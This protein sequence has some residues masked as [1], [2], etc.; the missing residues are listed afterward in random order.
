[1]T[2]LDQRIDPSPG[3]VLLHQGAT[4]AQHRGTSHEPRRR[5]AAIAPTRGAFSG[6]AE[7]PNPAS[8]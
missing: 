6:E 3:K 5:A 4:I 2:V 7:L 1:V 8:G